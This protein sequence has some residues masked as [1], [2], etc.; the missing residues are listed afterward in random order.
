MSNNSKPLTSLLDFIAQLFG[1]FHCS[2]PRCARPRATIPSH[3]GDYR[4]EALQGKDNR[5]AEVDNI[6]VG[7]CRNRSI[8]VGYGPTV[9]KGPG[10]RL[11]DRELQGKASS[12][13]LQERGVHEMGLREE[14]TGLGTQRSLEGLGQTC[15]HQ[16]QTGMDAV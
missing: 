7:L 9:C 4:R 10:Q 2:Q 15:G 12:L 13:P 16:D 1:L 6:Q 14:N 3:G 5:K 8:S 11:S